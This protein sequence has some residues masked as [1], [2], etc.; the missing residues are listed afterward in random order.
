MSGNTAF[1]ITKPFDL[2]VY[3]V[4]QNEFEYVMSRSPSW[5]SSGGGQADATT[6][7]DTGRYRTARRGHVWLHCACSCK[8]RETAREFG[9]ISEPSLTLRVGVSRA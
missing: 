1:R 8:R 2:G 6:E 9:G 5:F 4:A 3:E 7:V